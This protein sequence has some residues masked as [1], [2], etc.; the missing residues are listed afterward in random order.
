MAVDEAHCISEWGHAFRPDYLKVSRFVDEIKAERVVC[1]TATATPRVAEDICK[2]FGIDK[3]GLF[4]TTTYR[5]NLRLIAESSNDKQVL[6]DKLYSFLRKNPGPS[7]IYVTLQKQTE[8][9]AEDL[10]DQ[11]FMARSFH[12]GMATADKVKLQE[13]FMTEANLIIVATIAF[14]MGIDKPNVRN[15]V[16]F[17]IPNSVESYSQE[18][19]RAGRDGKLSNCLFYVCGQD[20]YLREVFA[21]GDL[22]SKESLRK[23][24]KDIFRP[25]NIQL[26]IG[27]TFEVSHLAQGKDFDIRANTLNNVYAQLELRYGLIRATTPIYTDYSYKACGSYGQVL[28]E[29]SSAAAAA[30]KAFAQIGRSIYKIDINAAAIS[31]KISRPDLIHKLNDWNELQHIEL[32]VS[33]VRNVYRVAKKLPSVP[34][35][36]ETI[37]D[38]L[39]AYMEERE[40][41][42]LD[43]TEQVL[44]FITARH[45]FCKALAQHFG[46]E[47]SDG[48][49]ECGHCTWCETRTPVSKP[50]MPKVEFNV[51]Q[52]GRVLA[53]VPDRH[54]PR[55]LARVAFGITSPRVTALKLQRE[56]PDA[57][58]GSMADHGFE[59]GGSAVSKPRV[60]SLL[61][62]FH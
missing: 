58:V 47:L 62:V 13:D 35:E 33:G 48:K 59:V 15:V 53:A 52:F 19:G 38:D 5:P 23:L 34:S 11:G 1:L 36:V 26:A 44:S 61:T 40:Q 42:A 3:S 28:K 20:L 8:A 29:D 46:D 4:R 37:A 32:K 7:I 50:I 31:G 6:Y 39:Y 27:K 12:A 56:G 16:H 9:L 49:T 60:F 2:A 54:D 18:I 14:G 25:T 55:L 51:Q 43:R 10:V 30:I 22:P 21:R 24:L 57:I 41:Q 17:N 45:C